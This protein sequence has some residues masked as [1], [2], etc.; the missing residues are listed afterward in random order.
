MK[1]VITV[2]QYQKIVFNLLDTLYGPNISVKKDEEIFEILSDHGEEIFRVY[3][4][5]GKSK[6]CKRDML[7]L[8][9]T[10]EEIERYLPPA[11]LRKKLFSRTILSYV[12]IFLMKYI[13]M[14]KLISKIDIGLTLKKIKRQ[15]LSKSPYIRSGFYFLYIYLIWT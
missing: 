11:V 7:V 12:L 14:M 10:I 8:S 15:Q 3:T 1:I 4:K 2:S 5:Q 6:G 13:I 9:Q